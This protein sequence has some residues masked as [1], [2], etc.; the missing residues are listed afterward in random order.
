MEGACLR[1]LDTVRR[2]SPRTADTIKQTI[3]ENG[4]LTPAEKAQQTDDVSDK[5]SW[6]QRE[7][8]LRALAS[9][10]GRQLRCTHYM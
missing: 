1:P 7:L 8:P 3:V 6:G 10:E 2:N 4:A 5:S 9:P